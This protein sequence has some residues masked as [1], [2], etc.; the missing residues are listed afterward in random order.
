MNK[1][2]S[3]KT[4]CKTNLTE[5]TKFLLSEIMGIEN[6]FR[7]EIN[8]RKS[9][10]KKSNKYVTVSDYIDQALIVLSEQVVEYQL[11]RLQMLLEHQLE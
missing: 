11:F 7:Q 5:Q 9:C 10:C 2:N 1:N 6:Y 3:I 8:Q 4:I